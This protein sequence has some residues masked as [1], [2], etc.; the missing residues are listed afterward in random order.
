MPNFSK[1]ENAFGKITFNTIIIREECSSLKRIHPNAFSYQSKNTRELSIEARNLISDKSLPN[2]FYDF[3]NSFENLEFLGYDSTIGTL[4]EKFG[5]NLNT[6]RKLFLR[7]DSIEGSPFSN[8]SEIR[9]LRLEDGHL[10]YLPKNALK[11]GKSN[12]SFAIFLSNNKLNGSSFE[13]GVLTSTSPKN[14]I[15]SLS[16]QANQI[17]YLDEAVF[18]PFLINQTHNYFGIISEPLDCDDCRSAWIC[19]SKESEQIKE[20]FFRDPKCVDGRLITD[21]SKNFLKC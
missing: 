21:C 8:M 17:K 10:N 6:I 20:T 2:F 9:I 14:V 15:V 12:G 5:K 13:K 3:V 4:K 16:L 7:V 19:K 11:F 1:P 18:K